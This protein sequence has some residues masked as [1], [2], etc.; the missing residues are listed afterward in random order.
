MKLFFIILIL[1]FIIFTLLFIFCACKI[2]SRADEMIEEMY[3]EK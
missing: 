3:Y 2:S 1:A